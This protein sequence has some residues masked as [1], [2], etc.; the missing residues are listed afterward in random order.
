MKFLFLAIFLLSS[1]A[2][3]AAQ[4]PCL[5]TLGELPAMHGIRLGAA[6]SEFEM[7]NISGEAGIRLPRNGGRPDLTHLENIW[8][9]FYKDRLTAVEFDYDRTT[10]WKNVREFAAVLETKPK[11]PFAAWV[12]IDTTEAKI[13]CQGF[14]VA[15]SSVRNTLHITDTAA[16][17]EAIRESR[18]T[19]KPLAPVHE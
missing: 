1:A 13:E 2:A 4:G 14:T 17:A 7:V 6:R 9:G 5:V 3:L 11:L 12:F 18:R 19:N 10:E 15:I 16:K 8:L